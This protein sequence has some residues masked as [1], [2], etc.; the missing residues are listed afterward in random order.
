[1]YSSMG[2]II[3]AHHMFQAR[4]FLDTQ[5]LATLIACAR[6]SA[7]PQE[8]ILSPERPTYPLA[9]GTKQVTS[10]AISEF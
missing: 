4:R 6:L 7:P 2:L 9:S 1:M 5:M 10:G 3:C 8:T